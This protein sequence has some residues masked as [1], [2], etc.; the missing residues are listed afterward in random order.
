MES[1]MSS[2]EVI[3]VWWLCGFPKKTKLTGGSSLWSGLDLIEY[4]II[5][6]TIQKY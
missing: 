1:T 2:K 4:N 3:Q 6:Q 5:Y